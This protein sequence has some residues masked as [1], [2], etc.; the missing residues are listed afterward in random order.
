MKILPFGHTVSIGG[1]RYGKGYFQ[2]SDF[3]TFSGNGSV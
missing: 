1:D 2:T 3:G